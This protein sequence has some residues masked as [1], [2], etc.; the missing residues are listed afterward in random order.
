MATSLTIRTATAHSN[1]LVAEC[2]M[3][4]GRGHADTSKGDEFTTFN[5]E[6]KRPSPF[7][8]HCCMYDNEEVV[9]LKGGRMGVGAI[10]VRGIAT[11]VNN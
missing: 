5:A 10:G 2:S 4:C 3:T 9:V 11:G 7:S 8:R 6:N 1:P